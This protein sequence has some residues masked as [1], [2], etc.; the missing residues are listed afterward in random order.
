MLFPFLTSSIQLCAEC[1]SQ[2]N[3]QEKEIKGMKIGKEEIKLYLFTDDMT[4]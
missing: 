2:Y 4:V 3:R 1:P